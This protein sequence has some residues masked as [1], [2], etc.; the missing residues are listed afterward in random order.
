LRP[1]L[2]ALAL[3][4]DDEIRIL[5]DR[6]VADRLLLAVRASESFFSSSAAAAGSASPLK[7]RLPSLKTFRPVDGLRMSLFGL[8]TISAVHLSASS[9]VKR[10]SP[11]FDSCSW[12][13]ANLFP[14]S[15]VNA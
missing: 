11:S 5:E 8:S 15:E 1:R 3:R 10:F 7:L 14:F 13:L 9:S 6:E 4:L 2:E 12:F